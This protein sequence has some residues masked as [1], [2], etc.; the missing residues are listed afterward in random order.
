MSQVFATQMGDDAQTEGAI[1]GG[2]CGIAVLVT[3]AG[4]AIVV[5][6]GVTVGQ[7]VA[8]TRVGGI[9]PVEEGGSV[10]GALVEGVKLELLFDALDSL[11]ASFLPAISVIRTAAR[12]TTK[13]T[14]APVQ[15]KCLEVVPGTLAA[16]C[17]TPLLGA[18]GG[19]KGSC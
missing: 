14:S 11:S 5:G 6:D 9:V 8:G 17:C 2:T 7:V 13:I 18:S 1:V 19:N 10:A 3:A 16:A 4:F 12:I 15:I